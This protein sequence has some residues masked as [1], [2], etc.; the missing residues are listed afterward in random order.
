MQAAVKVKVCGITNLPDAVAALE[1]GAEALGF[2]FYPPSPRF[3]RPELAAAIIAQLPRATCNVGV[4]VEASRQEVTRIAAQTG[5]M[6][7]QFHGNE[8]PDFCRSWR[9]TVIKGI[10]VC[11]RHAAAEALRYAVDF[12]LVDAY[13]EGHFGGTGKRIASELLEGFDRER[14]IL[15]GGLTPENVAAAVRMVRPFAV[16]VASGVERTPG[17]KDWDLMRRFIAHAHA[18]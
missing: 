17:K 4:F 1:A 12:I 6:A 10:R 16:D 14:L 3:V 18:A 8:S 5:V 13:V 9:Q 7:L 2:N 15:A 11:D